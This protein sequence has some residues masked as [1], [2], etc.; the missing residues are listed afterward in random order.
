MAALYQR[1]GHLLNSAMG[2]YPGAWLVWCDPRRDWLPLLQRAA[3]SPAP[4]NF[5]LLQVEEQT[6]GE[7]AGPASRRA[8]QEQVDRG[9]PFVL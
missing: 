7:L 5:M 3:E 2:S 4:G 6:Q 8:L 1:I 9:Q